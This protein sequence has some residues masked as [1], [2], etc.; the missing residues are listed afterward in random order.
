MRD[1]RYWE[2]QNFGFGFGVILVLIGVYLLGRDLGWWAEEISFWAVFF[3]VLGG[4]L[5]VK[6]IMIYIKSR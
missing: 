2:F 6:K 4:Y 1:V 3:L 5:I